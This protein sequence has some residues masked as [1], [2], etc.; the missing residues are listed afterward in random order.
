MQQRNPGR[1]EHIERDMQY[2][3]KTDALDVIHGP[4]RQARRDDRQRE[5]D[6]DVERDPMRER[7]MRDERGSPPSA[8]LRKF[9]D[10]GK[11]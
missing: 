6:A 11:A 10:V 9:A 4:P 8:K 5:D 2:A 3:P 7:A 1:A